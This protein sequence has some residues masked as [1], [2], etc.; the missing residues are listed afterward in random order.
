MH[1]GA[2]PAQ[3]GVR[4]DARAFTRDDIG[5]HRSIQGAFVLH[6]LLVKFQ[7][8]EDPELHFSNEL[9]W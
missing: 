5:D 8:Q 4:A 2:V 7:V 3:N 6:N 1:T 9:K